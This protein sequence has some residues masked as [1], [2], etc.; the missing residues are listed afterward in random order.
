MILRPPAPWDEPGELPFPA[1]RRLNVTTSEVA[2]TL[3]EIFRRPGTRYLEGTG[4]HLRRGTDPSVVAFDPGGERFDPWTL[5]WY[6]RRTGEPVRITTDP[7]EIDA[8][9]LDTLDSRAIDWAT[10]RPPAP[11]ESVT[12]DPM[13]IRIV[14]AVSGVIDA[15]LDGLADPGAYRTVYREAD[16]AAM[17]RAEAARMGPREF[18]RRTDLSL[19]VAQRAATGERISSKSIR[20][21]LRALA[22]NVASRV[23][24]LEGCDEPLPSARAQYCS[25][26]HRDRAYRLRHQQ[27]P[28]EQPADIPDGLVD[29]TPGHP[30]CAHC[31]T[32]LLG[33]AAVR[34]TCSRHADGY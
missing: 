25:K 8:V 20:T 24:A 14:G 31:D 1:I 2:K 15:S 29:D 10:K 34:G 28:G 12:V 33:L 26:G 4:S 5:T 32:V 23:C 30:T 22:Q 27:G 3:P 9:L 7:G 16:V 18:R 21:A 17:V 6:D 19:G 13:R 11:I